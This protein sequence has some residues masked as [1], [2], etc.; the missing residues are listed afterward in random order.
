MNRLDDY[1]E[2]TKPKRG[3]SCFRVGLVGATHRGILVK[4]E[5]FSEKLIRHRDGQHWRFIKKDDPDDQD[6][7]LVALLATIP[8]EVI[9]SVDWDGDEYTWFPHVF[10]SFQYRGAPFEHLA[11]Y[12]K[13]PGAHPDNSPYYKEVELFDDVCT[14]SSDPGDP[15]K[16]ITGL[17]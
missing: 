1:P 3:S 16:E 15:I 14:F 8:Y 11:F 6:Q 12:S 13:H 2:P 4:V 7:I 17:L 10:C 5:P 9:D